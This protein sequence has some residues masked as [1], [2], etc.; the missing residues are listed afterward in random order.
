MVEDSH[1]EG[2]TPHALLHGKGPMSVD[3][4]GSGTTTLMRFF[5]RDASDARANADTADKT[6]TSM[7]EKQEAD[8]MEAAMDAAVASASFACAALTYMVPPPSSFLGAIALKQDAKEAG[9]GHVSTGGG[10]VSDEDVVGIAV[11]GCSFSSPSHTGGVVEEKMPQREKMPQSVL[12][13][14]KKMPQE[15]MPQRV[16]MT[17]SVLSQSSLGEV[18][19]EVVERMQSGEAVPG[20]KITTPL[21]T[22]AAV[23]T[24]AMEQ[25]SVPA[26]EQH[27]AETVPAIAST[28][29]PITTHALAPMT[30]HVLAPMTTPLTIPRQRRNM[31]SLPVHGEGL[32][33]CDLLE[34]AVHDTSTMGTAGDESSPCSASR[35]KRKRV[36]EGTIDQSPQQLSGTGDKEEGIRTSERK[37]GKRGGAF[38]SPSAA[39][40][41]IVA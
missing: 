15:K 34:A 24:S 12:M 37:R 8:K 16:L 26:M 2:N 27:T 41:L 30:T 31:R 11:K 10:G 13:P 1:G 6:H 28:C 4:K 22:A 17:H 7:S 36:Q 5:D 21:R 19:G 39:K 40:T 32:G 14:Q 38:P 18:V 25:H 33:T 9:G 20:A 3:T 23:D 29:A 35:S